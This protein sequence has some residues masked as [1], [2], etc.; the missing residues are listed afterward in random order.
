VL[1]HRG[2]RSV[3]TDRDAGLGPAEELVPGEAGDVDARF[4]HLAHGRLA[5]AGH[6]RA[7]AEVLEQE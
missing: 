1:S 2:D 4:D 5:E 7:G 3:A 6:D